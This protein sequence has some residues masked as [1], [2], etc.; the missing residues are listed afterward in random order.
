MAVFSLVAKDR[1][2]A[3]KSWK[4]IQANVQG[5]KPLFFKDMYFL[6]ICMHLCL[7]V[8][9]SAVPK[10]ARKGCWRLEL[11]LHTGGW[12]LPDMGAGS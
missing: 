2:L 7:R 3:F 10:E 11:E 9:T 1:S 6:I 12:E 5:Y 8:S 4:G